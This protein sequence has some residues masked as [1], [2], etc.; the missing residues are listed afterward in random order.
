MDRREAPRGHRRHTWSSRA[1]CGRP[2]PRSRTATPVL[3]DEV[4]HEITD[5]PIASRR[6]CSRCGFARITGLQGTEQLQP[7]QVHFDLK[8]ALG[9]PEAVISDNTITFGDPV[10][11]GDLIT[12]AQILRSVS[13]EKTTKLGTGASG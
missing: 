10:R 12:S 9:L 4:A 2:A 13:D 8:E 11:I 6:R 5:G 3:D 7:L 1:T